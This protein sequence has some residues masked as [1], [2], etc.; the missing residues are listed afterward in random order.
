MSHVG[1]KHRGRGWIQIQLLPP[2]IYLST[3]YIWI[4]PRTLSLVGC[5]EPGL[6]IHGVMQCEAQQ[7]SYY[8]DGTL[9]GCGLRR[10][11]GWERGGEGVEVEHLELAESECLFLD[12]LTAICCKRHRWVLEMLHTQICMF[13]NYIFNYYKINDVYTM[14]WICKCLNFFFLQRWLQF[15]VLC[16]IDEFNKGSFIILRSI[17]MWLK[18]DSLW[19]GD[20]KRLWM[21][22]CL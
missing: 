12:C 9:Q 15:K 16:S 2:Y 6:E 19:L 20:I 5:S 11:P 13:L 4:Q 22:L 17:F 8:R 7:N 1:S 18:F 14:F 10:S 3:P 21:L